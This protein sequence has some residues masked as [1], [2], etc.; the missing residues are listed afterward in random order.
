M[1][2]KHSDGTISMQETISCFSLISDPSPS[3]CSMNEDSILKR[4]S[5]F[6]CLGDKNGRIPIMG[7]KRSKMCTIRARWHIVDVEIE[8]PLAIEIQLDGE[9]IEWIRSCGAHDGPWR[10]CKLKGGR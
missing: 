2:T 10:L 5:T 7:F 6:H 8:E 9:G 3:I 1:F 4:N